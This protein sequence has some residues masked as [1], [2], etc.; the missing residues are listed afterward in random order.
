MCLR[1]LSGR[2]HHLGQSGRKAFAGGRGAACLPL[3][4]ETNPKWSLFRE[5][6]LHSDVSQ[7]SLRLRSIF[8]INY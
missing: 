6:K 7:S 4:E 1:S 3:Q 2:C 5:I 8:E